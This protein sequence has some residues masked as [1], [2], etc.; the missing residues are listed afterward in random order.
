M[1][2][3]ISNVKRTTKVS[4]AKKRKISSAIS[5]C[6]PQFIGRVSTLA[7]HTYILKCEP[8]YHQI[9]HTMTV[10]MRNVKRTSEVSAEKK[11]KK[12]HDS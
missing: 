1:K 12:S 11:V 10:P 3:P 4:I 5:A 2:V 8:A 9:A 6:K 7:R